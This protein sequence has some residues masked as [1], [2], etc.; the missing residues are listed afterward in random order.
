MRERKIV[1]RVADDVSVRRGEACPPQ[2]HN[3]GTSTGSDVG[4]LSVGGMGRRSD[5]TNR[6]NP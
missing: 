5:G 2:L 3:R 4:Y 1:E 6:Q